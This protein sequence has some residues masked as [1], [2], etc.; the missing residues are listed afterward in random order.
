MFYFEKCSNGH[1]FLIFSLQREINEVLEQRKSNGAAAPEQSLHDQNDI[2][3]NR[4]RFEPFQTGR[5]QSHS[6]IDF[7]KR[8]NLRDAH[9]K[10]N[11]K[12]IR[13]ASSLNASI[14]SNHGSNMRKTNEWADSILK[15]LDN[16]IL[17]NQRYADSV[18]QSIGSNASDD[19]T[20]TGPPKLPQKRSTIINVVLR[21]TTPSPS[22]TSPTAPT[23]FASTPTNLNKNQTAIISASAAAVVA[24]PKDNNK[25]PKPE[26]HVSS[27][28]FSFQLPRSTLTLYLLVMFIIII[29]YVASL[30][31]TIFI[32]CVCVT[33]RCYLV[34]CFRHLC[35]N[36][37]DHHLYH[38]SCG[39]RFDIANCCK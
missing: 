12:I 37:F 7:M 10:L 26:K 16:L 38:L 25:I 15:D 5:G 21:K 18:N 35:S 8:D 22:P 13:N 14:A 19:G 20:A 9:S 34:I 31:F 11:A 4:E 3:R 24:A 27:F 17:S 32:C 39:V 36:P 6:G 23:A 30:F 1:S 28:G 33:I 2:I 29:E